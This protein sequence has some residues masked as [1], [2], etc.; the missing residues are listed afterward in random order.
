MKVK[1]R[2]HQREVERPFSQSF[3]LSTTANVLLP[4]T[5]MLRDFE[6]SSSVRSNQLAPL[7]RKLNVEKLIVKGAVAHSV[8]HAPSNKTFTTFEATKERFDKHQGDCP[9][10]FERV[11]QGRSRAGFFLGFVSGLQG[12]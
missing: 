2:L 9:S 1:A 5:I 10:S 6:V 11:L 7:Y 3:N 12:I 4:T 8:V